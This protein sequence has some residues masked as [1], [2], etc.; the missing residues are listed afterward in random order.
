MFCFEVPDEIVHIF[1]RAGEQGKKVEKTKQEAALRAKNRA[2]KV[3]K[4][5]EAIQGEEETAANID[6]S[7]ALDE[8]RGNLRN[9]L[10]A[11][12]K[13]GAEKW[14]SSLRHEMKKAGVHLA[15]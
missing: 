9:A 13:R 10:D 5:A 4:A 12:K 6:A 8:V 1:D 3:K 2:D 14:A 7:K 15:T 11:E